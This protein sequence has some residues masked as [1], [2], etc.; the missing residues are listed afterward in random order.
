MSF[1]ESARLSATDS[2]AYP[3]RWPVA[4]NLWRGIDASV[5]HTPEMEYMRLTGWRSKGWVAGRSFR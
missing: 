3:A 5:G 4:D 1:Y 2:R